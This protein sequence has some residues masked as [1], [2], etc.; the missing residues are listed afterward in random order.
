MTYCV[1]AR[2]SGHLPGAKGQNVSGTVLFTVTS[3]GVLSKPFVASRN[4]EDLGVEWTHKSFTNI[5]RYARERG[6][7][8]VA[9]E[10]EDAVYDLIPRDYLEQVQLFPGFTLNESP[11]CIYR[12]PS[13]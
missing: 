10:D 12:K 11:C 8:K 13:L 9:F 4:C 1:F 7:E 3:E 5:P 2:V 6:L